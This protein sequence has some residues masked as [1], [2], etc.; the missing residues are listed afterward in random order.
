MRA[1][2]EVCQCLPN[3]QTP[4]IEKLNNSDTN[5]P[6]EFQPPQQPNFER[7]WLEALSAFP[8][9]LLL[10]LARGPG[11]IF[12]CESFLTAAKPPTECLVFG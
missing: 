3:T 6:P 12:L 7:L 10:C 1:S 2:P 9:A 11:E 8:A 5:F 4:A